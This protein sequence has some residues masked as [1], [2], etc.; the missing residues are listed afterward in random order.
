MRTLLWGLLIWSAINAYSSLA[1]KFNWP[2]LPGEF[3]FWAL[4]V[5]YLLV[6]FG[7]IDQLR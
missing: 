5:A 6:V 3:S 4:L 1:S 7:S 2:S